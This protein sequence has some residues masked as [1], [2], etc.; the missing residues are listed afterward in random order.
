MRYGAN[1]KEIM[2]DFTA[3][4]IVV[5]SENQSGEKLLLDQQLDYIALEDFQERLKDKTFTKTIS[6]NKEG[7]LAALEAEIERIK[8]LKEEIEIDKQFEND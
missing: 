4:N 3:D 7:L 5:K 6:E 1:P 8:K 2:N